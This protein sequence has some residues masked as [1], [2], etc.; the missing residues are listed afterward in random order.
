MTVLWHLVPLLQAHRAPDWI[1]WWALN[2]VGIRVLTVWIYNSTGRSVF[3]AVLFHG[4]VNLATYLLP[5]YSSHWEP[6][7]IGPVTAAAAAIVAIVWSPR[8]LR[9]PGSF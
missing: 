4:F 2:A 1:A 9:S 7:V 3:A 8:T 6:G 5:V